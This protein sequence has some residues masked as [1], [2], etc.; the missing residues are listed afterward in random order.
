MDLD[1]VIAR[2][3]KFEGRVPHMYRCTGGEVTIGMGHAILSAPEC[4]QLDWAAGAGKAQADWAVVA[5]APKGQAASVYA[6]LTTCRMSDDAISRLAAADVQRF[7]QLLKNSFPKWDAYPAPA[8]AALF[9]MAFNLGING[10][11]AFHNMLAAVDAGQWESAAQQ[12]HRMGINDAR[13]QETAA[14]FRQAAG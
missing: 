1:Q 6:H 5:A 2:I 8:Q 4:A 9:D 10:L 14:L 7:H 12:C 11:K 13:N 3:E